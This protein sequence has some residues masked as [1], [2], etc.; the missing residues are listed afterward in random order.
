MLARNGLRLPR[1]VFTELSFGTGRAVDGDLELVLN[2]TG[3]HRLP[4]LLR[5][6][7]FP[8]ALNA[9]APWLERLIAAS[10]TSP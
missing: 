7:A 2:A 6:S 4:A 1:F 9:Q 3:K 5:A 10:S 8:A